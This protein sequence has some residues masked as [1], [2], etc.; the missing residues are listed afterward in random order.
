[1]KLKTKIQ[2]SFNIESDSLDG[3]NFSFNIEKEKMKQKT[4]IT[5]VKK[6]RKIKQDVSTRLF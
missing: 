4:K 1:M 3:F 6:T 5:E 2:H